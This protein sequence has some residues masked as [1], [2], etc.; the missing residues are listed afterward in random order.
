MMRKIKKAVEPKGS[1]AF[2]RRNTKSPAGFYSRRAM[3]L[4]CCRDFAVKFHW[5]EFVMGPR[6]VPDIFLG[7]GAPASAI[8]RSAI[9][10]LACSAAS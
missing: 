1:T 10:Q 9:N 8:D 6:A 3:L 4:K 7:D 2:L 5:V